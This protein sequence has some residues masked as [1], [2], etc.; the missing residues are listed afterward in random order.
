[1]LNKTN[2]I[3]TTF[4]NWLSIYLFGLYKNAKIE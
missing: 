1:M 2:G 3:Y 4:N